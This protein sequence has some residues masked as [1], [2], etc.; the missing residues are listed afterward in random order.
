MIQPIMPP[1]ASI[2]SCLG[3]SRAG[4]AESPHLSVTSC[5]FCPL[6]R[7]SAAADLVWEGYAPYSNDLHLLATGLFNTAASF[8][9]S[10]AIN[11][12]R[13]LLSSL[14]PLNIEQNQFYRWERYTSSHVRLRVIRKPLAQRIPPSGRSP[15]NS[16]PYAGECS[17]DRMLSSCPDGSEQKCYLPD[18]SPR[19]CCLSRKHYLARHINQAHQRIQAHLPHGFLRSCTSAFLGEHPPGSRNVSGPPLPLPLP[20]HPAAL[21]YLQIKAFFSEQTDSWL[22]R[23]LPATNCPLDPCISQLLVL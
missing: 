9:P 11:K 22:P 6:C 20:K 18:C 23:L 7:L 14:R 17:A 13:L 4:P 10:I 3:V 12:N 15:I 16:L 2:A 19:I 1:K 5:L 21:S 8:S